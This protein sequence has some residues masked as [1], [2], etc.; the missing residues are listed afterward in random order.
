MKMSGKKKDMFGM[1]IINQE[2]T[3]NI[4][5]ADAIATAAHAMTVQKEDAVASTFSDVAKIKKV[6]KFDYPLH[7]HFNRTYPRFFYSQIFQSKLS[8]IA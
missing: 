4:A 2:I 6:V 7:N 1:M 3:T 5:L 8:M